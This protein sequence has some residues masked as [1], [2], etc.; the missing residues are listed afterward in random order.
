MSPSKSET[1]KAL[2][3]LIETAK[4]EN[5]K[6]YDGLVNLLVWLTNDDTREATFRTVI[7]GTN[8]PDGATNLLEEV[9]TIMR[10]VANGGDVWRDFL[11]EAQEVQVLAGF[12]YRTPTK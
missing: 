12:L 11:F 7:G 8:R 4:A 9:I 6:P 2:K 3:V 5:A 1:H 10:W